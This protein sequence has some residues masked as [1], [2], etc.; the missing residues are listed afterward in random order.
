MAGDTVIIRFS[1]FFNFMFSLLFIP[2]AVAETSISVSETTQSESYR[3]TKDLSDRAPALINVELNDEE[4][5]WLKAQ[6]TISVGFSK[7]DRRPLSYYNEDGNISGVLPAFVSLIFQRLNIKNKLRIRTYDST[8]EMFHALEKKDV[9]ILPGFTPTPKRVKK[10]AFSQPI[11]S[12]SVS[13]IVKNNIDLTD[14][15]NLDNITWG[16][17]RDS[18]FCS[19]LESGGVTKIVPVTHFDEANELLLNGSIDGYISYHNTLV[20][21]LASM[22]DIK[23]V[24]VDKLG[25]KYLHLS[26][27]KDNLMLNK[28]LNKAI[29]SISE[30]ERNRILSLA[31]S[32]YTKYES[33]GAIDDVLERYR[34]LKNEH[35]TYTT[36]ADLDILNESNKDAIPT[37]YM[38]ELLNIISEYSGIKFQHLELPNTP[39]QAQQAIYETVL[40]SI[41]ILPV[42]NSPVKL[43]SSFLITQPFDNIK[44]VLI[45]QRS[46]HN[47]TFPN[48]TTKNV[49]M[50]YQ[51][52]IDSN[53]I[54]LPNSQITEF[55]SLPAMLS[56]LKKG[57]INYLLLSKSYYYGNKFEQYISNFTLLPQFQNINLPIS[58]AINNNQFELYKMI[59]RTLDMIPKDRLKALKQKYLG[60]TIKE[61]YS[62]EYVQALIWKYSGILFACLFMI[63][64]WYL[65]IKKKIKHRENLQYQANLR[66][67]L[68]ENALNSIA[69]IVYVK[70]FDDTLLL[71]NNAYSET[72]NRHLAPDEATA[73]RMYGD[74]DIVIKHGEEISNTGKFSNQTEAFDLIYS[75]TLF[76]D[77]N[78]K[79]L[80]IMTVATDVT[81]IVTARREAEQAQ[82]ARSNFL[83]TMSHELRTP[84]AGL[85]SLIGLLDGGNAD[86]QSIIIDNLKFST[87]HLNYLVNDILDYSQIEAGQLKLVAENT[88]LMLSVSS[89]LRPLYQSAAEKG[90]NVELTWVPHPKHN[91]TID[92]TRINQILVNI[93][94]NAIKFTQQGSITVMLDLAP[95]QITIQITDTG[96]GIPEDKVAHIFKPFEQGDSSINRN[97]G[98]TGLGLSIC[99]SLVDQMQGSIRL[100]SEYLQGTDVVFSI[101]MLANDHEG[102]ALPHTQL[103]ALIGIDKSIRAWFDCWHV[104]YI[105]ATDI[106][107]VPNSKQAIIVISNTD[108]IK[109]Y[110][111]NWLQVISVLSYQF[112]IITSNDCNC[113]CNTNNITTIETKPFYPTDLYQLLVKQNKKTTITSNH[114][115]EIYPLSGNILIAE[116]HL[117]NQLIIKRYLNEMGLNYSIAHN[118]AEAIELLQQTDYDLLITDCHMPNVN[119]YQLSQYVINADELQM[120]IIGMTADL[121]DTALKQCIDAG[122][123]EV[124][125]K[126]FSAIQLHKMLVQLLPIKSP[127]VTNVRQIEERHDDTDPELDWLQLFDNPDDAKE[128]ATTLVDSIVIDSTE[129]I[130]HINQRDWSQVAQVAHR[131]KGAVA[132]IG[133]TELVSDAQALQTTAETQ[134]QEEEINT[135]SQVLLYK[136]NRLSTKVQNWL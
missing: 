127:Q 108:V 73:K 15:Q 87:E 62:A 80:G 74:N 111:V 71:S 91:V 30:F 105:E 54:N 45:Q 2:I 26:S 38:V 116:D 22:K 37:G 99:K 117:V 46:G 10:Y 121:S 119:G 20:N 101:P 47:Q 32:K 64:L 128:M 68:L 110:G 95:H 8:A 65:F 18:A 93:V 44:Y 41:D 76:K 40:N 3:I 1:L 5:N 9:D 50:L 98:G 57:Q 120:N 35:F 36:S 49:G 135:L 67:D 53:L 17:R 102:I 78:N 63:F 43:N 75:K 51:P 52:L 92:A 31:N 4:I 14:K 124:L 112:I 72:K 113:N 25:Q 39:A 24:S 7:F 34:A 82:Q 96:I 6:T 29:S 109:Q 60:V 122:M 90:L 48:L 28:I 66:K 61:G 12:L 104:N 69:N 59:V 23:L 89:A 58:L 16:C 79:A 103:Y 55:S 33:I 134:Q 13:V 94:S 118:G 86:D 11:L 100:T 70:S 88:D 132:M 130:Q 106:D 125:F 81:E 56:A 136:L 131:I 114:S 107:N 115:Y 133:L 84:I 126:P 129:L 42:V 85:H 97:F 123:N 19:L 27:A 77:R 83:A 21:N